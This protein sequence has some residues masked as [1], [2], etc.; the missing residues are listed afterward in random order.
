MI[1]EEHFNPTIHHLD[2]NWYITHKLIKPIDQLFSEIPNEKYSSTLY[3]PKGKRKAITL[4][5]PAE[6]IYYSIRDGIDPTL[7][8]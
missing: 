6:Y 2:I 4:I 8:F 7:L 3:I 1:L 5:Q